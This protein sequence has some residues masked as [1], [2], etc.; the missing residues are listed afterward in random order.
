MTIQDMTPF[1]LFSLGIVEK[2]DGTFYSQVVLAYDSGGYGMKEI[3]GHFGLHYSR[4]SRIINGLGS[5]KDKP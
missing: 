4:V 3:G 2:D 1:M 5:A